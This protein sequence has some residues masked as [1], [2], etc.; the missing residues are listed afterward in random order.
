MSVSHG[1]SQSS[2]VDDSAASL[3]S[4]H[5]RGALRIHFARERES[6]TQCA[7]FLGPRQRFETQ[8]ADAREQRARHARAVGIFE[9]PLAE[10][11]RTQPALI[12]RDDGLLA[13]IPLE[14][15]PMLDECGEVRFERCTRQR[16]GEPDERLAIASVEIRDDQELRLRD[17]LRVREPRTAS[18]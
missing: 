9:S 1:A 17:A 2:S 3:T 14:P 7:R 5:G 12:L 16:R 13:R 10:P 18:A 15:L 6:L 4:G 11:D 8:L